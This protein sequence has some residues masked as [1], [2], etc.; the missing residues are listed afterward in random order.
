MPAGVQLKL[1]SVNVYT[2]YI[3]VT[4]VQLTSA[5]GFQNALA[6]AQDIAVIT[7]ATFAAGNTAVFVHHT[8]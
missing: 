5:L 3:V 2:T 1:N 7:L 8:L 4:A 6:A